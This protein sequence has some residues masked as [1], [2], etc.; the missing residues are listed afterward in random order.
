MAAH[1]LAGLTYKGVDELGPTELLL[2]FS[3]LR[4]TTQLCPVLPFSKH[5]TLFH[6]SVQADILISLLRT[7]LPPSS[8]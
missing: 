7:L 2:A 6:S 4:H 3:P 1:S 8:S 5:A